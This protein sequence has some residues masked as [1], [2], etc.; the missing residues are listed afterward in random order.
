MGT[1]AADSTD[2]VLARVLGDGH[3][4]RGDVLAD[5]T[6][7][8]TAAWAAAPPRQLELCRVRI[9]SMLGCEAE[10]TART[11]GTGLDPD[12]L[13]SIAD[14]PS[15]ARFGPADRACLAFTEHYVI[16]VASLDDA[17]VAA[18]REHLGDAGLQDFVSALL[19]VEQRIRLRLAWDRLLGGTPHGT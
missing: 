17:T 13:A 16:D 14:W 18:V 6:A 15:D 11:D 5:M 19:V 7:A 3:T 10:A 1:L 2:E 9:A 8:H 4:G 12:Q